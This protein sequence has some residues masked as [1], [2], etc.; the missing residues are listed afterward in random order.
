MRHQF[1][2]ALDQSIAMDFG[3]RS[4]SGNVEGLLKRLPKCGVF[5]QC[6]CGHVNE[7]NQ[8]NATHQRICRGEYFVA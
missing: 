6:V 8:C 2:C 5:I 4:F 1:L 3:K 7:R